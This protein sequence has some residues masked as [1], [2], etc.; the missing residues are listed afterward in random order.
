MAGTLLLMLKAK[1]FSSFYFA[2]WKKNV[3]KLTPM[4]Q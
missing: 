1:E 2:K 4:Q 3:H